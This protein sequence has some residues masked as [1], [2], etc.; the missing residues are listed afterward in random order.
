VQDEPGPVV[1]KI[2]RV[3]FSFPTSN[4]FQFGV[5]AIASSALSLA[6]PRAVEHYEGRDLL[7]YSDGAE[8]CRAV[9]DANG[10]A[11]PVAFGASCV[12]PTCGGAASGVVLDLAIDELRGKLYYVIAGPKGCI[13][14]FDAD[15][16]DQ[17]P[18]ADEAIPGATDLADPRAVA[19]SDSFLFYSDAEQLS[20]RSFNS[21]IRAGSPLS[22]PR[23]QSRRRAPQQH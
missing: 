10:D 12:Q 7:A 3:D 17:V 13:G 19:V 4:S 9:L 6:E 8:V 23:R 15:F 22:S 5:P 14:R 18:L 16:G 21:S 1:D 11:S 20:Q 2:W